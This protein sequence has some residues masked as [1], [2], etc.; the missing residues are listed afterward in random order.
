MRFRVFLHP[1]SSCSDPGSDISTE[2]VEEVQ[3]EECSKVLVQ[4]SKWVYKQRIQRAAS[5]SGIHSC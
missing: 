4:R 1:G 3:E 5:K 2:T